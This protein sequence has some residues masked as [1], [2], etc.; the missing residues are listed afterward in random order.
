MESPRP[1]FGRVRGVLG[2]SFS[3]F[4]AGN[5]LE[6]RSSPGKTVDIML[7]AMIL[8]HCMCTH[9][10]LASGKCVGVSLGAGSWW[11]VAG[12]EGVVLLE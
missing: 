7:C 4:S 5:I 11:L 2:V 9:L 12:G 3:L 1:I 6:V 10:F 8:F